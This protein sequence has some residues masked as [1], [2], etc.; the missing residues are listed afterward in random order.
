MKRCTPVALGIVVLFAAAVRAEGEKAAGNKPLGTW[1]RTVGD[2][3]LTFEFKADG[4]R[5]VLAA[6]G[7]TIEM[8]GDYGMTK[9][10]V[11]FGRVAKVEKKGTNDGPSE[12][13]LFSF[14]VKVDKDTLSL[15]ELKT[16]NDS[17][18]AKQLIEGDYQKQK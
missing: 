17:A 12:G 3:S 6:G 13:D 10:G 9:D 16:H 5:C 1:K 7:N 2:A 11:L 15:S 4:M 8:D 14:K 18:E